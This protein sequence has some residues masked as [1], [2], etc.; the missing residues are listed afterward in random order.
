[1][2]KLVVYANPDDKAIKMAP[3]DVSVVY[4][5]SE[6]TVTDNELETYTSFGPFDIE[7]KTSKLSPPQ[8]DENSFVTT[9]RTLADGSV[10]ADVE[11]ELIEVVGAK[12]YEIR[13]A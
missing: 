1:M 3:D 4:F 7:Q 10:V 9:I 2:S 6:D 12:S 5:N 8:I 11:F 13:Y